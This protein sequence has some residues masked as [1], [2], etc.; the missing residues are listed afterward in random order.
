M[1]DR[2]REAKNDFKYIT[3]AIC[4]RSYLFREDAMIHI[5]NSFGPSGF[6]F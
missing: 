2:E 6:A 1:K 3:I 5:Y 4:L